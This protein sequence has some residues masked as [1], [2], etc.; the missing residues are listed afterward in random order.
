MMYLI[1]CADKSTSDNVLWW[2][3]NRHGYT[4]NLDEAGRYTKEDAEAQAAA[5]DLDFA[6]PEDAIGTALKTHRVVS[7]EWN[8]AVLKSIRSS[9]KAP[10]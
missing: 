2:R 6:I 7:K 1:L 10:A 4:Y 3:P 8:Y 5:R 9:G